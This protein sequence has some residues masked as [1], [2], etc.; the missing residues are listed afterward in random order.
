MRSGYCICRALLFAAA[1][2]FDPCGVFAQTVDPRKYGIDL[3]AGSIQPSN[4]ETVTT[5][6]EDGKP[7]VGRIHLRIGDGAVI[8]LPD[9]RLISRPAGRFASTERPFAPLSKEQVSSQLAAEF[10]GFKTKATNHYVYA[11]DTSDEFILGASRILET[12]LPGVKNYVE[13]S[14]LKVQTPEFPLV[15]VLFR[16]ERDFQ[17]YCRKQGG[18]VANQD[19]VVAYYDP[20]SNRVVLYEQSPLAEVHPKLALQLAIS[21]IA[22]EGVHQI[23]HNIGVQER[24]SVWPLWLSEGLAEY[25]APTSTDDRLHW[26]GAGQI[27]DLRMFELEKYLQSNAA[28]DPSGELVEHTVLAGQLTSTGYASAWALTHFLAK[29]RRADFNDLLKA[30]SQLKPLEGAVDVAATGVVRSN[31]EEFE[32]RFGDN[33]REHE[34]RLVLYLKNQPYNDPFANAPHF[35]ATLIA[36]K[37]KQ[38]EKKARTFTTL[39]LA[40]QW[41]SESVREL[42]ATQRDAAQKSIRAFPNRIQAEA[43]AEQWR[44]RA[45]KQ[46]ANRNANR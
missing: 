17:R 1:I 24:L 20:L 34:K 11:Y 22:H 16:N 3:P 6:D 41:L 13:Q 7:A 37:K 38:P 40:H 8:L 27:N 19:G 36:G 12:M 33:F 10:P 15:V 30:A 21:T 46:G 2:T 9:G 14:K 44:S 23:L 45:L 18:V 29:T 28:K 5:D 26:K 39:Q 32:T 42:P 4:R 43:Y 31:R 25:F 35:V